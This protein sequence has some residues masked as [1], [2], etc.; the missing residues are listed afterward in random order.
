MTI[1]M[2]EAVT[3]ASLTKAQPDRRTTPLFYFGGA[4]ACFDELQRSMDCGFPGIVTQRSRATEL[5]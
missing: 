5:V 4:T 2:I 3:L 1:D